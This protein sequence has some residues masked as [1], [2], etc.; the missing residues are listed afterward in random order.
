M[1]VDPWGALGPVGTARLQDSWREAAAARAL[2][3]ARDAVTAALR[4]LAVADDVEWVGGPAARY[5]AGLD[6]VADLTRAARVRLE[7]AVAAAEEHAAAVAR[8]GAVALGAPPSWPPSSSAPTSAWPGT[9]ARGDDG[10]VPG[11]GRS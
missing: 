9:I 10:L 5:R 2:D 3:R 8:L 4:R 1:T 7:A 11:F 6:D